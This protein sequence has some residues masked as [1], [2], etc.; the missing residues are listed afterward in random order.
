MP[1]LI[2]GA[3]RCALHP[4]THT[5]GGRGTDA[6]PL[7]A[8]D[9]HSPVA[10]ITVPPPGSGPVLIRRTT[11][12][13]VVR[14]DHEPMGIAPAELHD[15]AVIGFEGWQLTYAT[16]NTGAPAVGL[17]VP[18]GGGEWERPVPRTREPAVQL[19]A[20]G[21]IGARLVNMKT[22]L[23]FAL[24]DRR[25]VIGRD[26]SCDVVISGKGISRR[27]AS[28]SPVGG[29]YLLRDESANGTMVNGAPVAGTYLLTHGDV[30]RMDEEELRFDV[31]GM[32]ATAAPAKESEATQILDLSHITRGM[33][34]ATKGRRISCS[35]EIVRGP[36]AGA[37]FELDKPVCA[38][39][40]ARHNDV[41]VRD[42][43]VSSTH[44]TLL[45]K[46]A[47]WYVVD[48]RSANGTFVDGSRVAGERELPPGARL[49]VGAVEMIFRSFSDGV[50]EG[51][52]RRI[53]A[54][55]REWL[56]TLIRGPNRP[57]DFA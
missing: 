46:G 32:T 25:V 54:G 55:L 35:L 15:G 24:I 26:D 19:V 38:I 36:F 16:D 5:L 49:K 34:G 23:A 29:G 17:D 50:E 52:A 4:G 31:E 21:G 51:G 57:A 45:R 2:L 42:D 13:V 27:H 11:A 30:V 40:R 41:K 39:G 47:V 6:L 28:I 44:A 14:L 56:T 9:W 48:L 33:S 18:M 8:L 10:T 22:G 37:T 43:S 1:L 20:A 53:K 7:S 3:D 12:A